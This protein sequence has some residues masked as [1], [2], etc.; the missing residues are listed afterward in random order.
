MLVSHP[1]PTSSRL[2]GF[3][4]IAFLALLLAAI[5]PGCSTTRD[6]GVRYIRDDSLDFF[7]PLCGDERLQRLWLEVE[8]D[9]ETALTGDLL[10]SI[11]AEGS[12]RPVT[13]VALGDV[14]AGFRTTQDISLSELDGGF[15]HQTLRINATTNRASRLTGAFELAR[16]PTDGRAALLIGHYNDPD[17]VMT[18][19]Q[20]IDKQQ[21]QCKPWG[22]PVSIVRIGL[23][24][25]GGILGWYIIRYRRSK[26]RRVGTVR[27]SV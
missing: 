14:P 9:D 17:E 19:D 10:W 15:S 21:D 18:V 7:V 1:P 20:L 4:R 24:A 27:P 6:L 25:A 2:L 12:G 11:E 26:L 5:V 22:P 16:L 23:L 3:P 8:P 13:R